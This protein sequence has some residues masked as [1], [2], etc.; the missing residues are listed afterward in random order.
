MVCFMPDRHSMHGSSSTNS[1][2]ISDGTHK[3]LFGTVAV[4][5]VNR[6]A[7]CA[8]DRE[9]GIAPSIG[10]AFEN[11]AAAAVQL[12]CEG[13]SS[14]VTWSLISVCNNYFGYRCDHNR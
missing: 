14:G 7:P 13:S 1:S 11:D 3:P 4:R 12:L 6:L 2:S 5:D 10:V 9:H 8:A